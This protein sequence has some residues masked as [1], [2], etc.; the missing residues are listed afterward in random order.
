M[1]PQPWSDRRVEIVI[2]T[3]LRVGVTIAA[4]VVAAGG[5]VYLAHHGGA[6]ADYRVFQGEPADL[7]GLAGIWR[8]A[9]A[10]SGRGII[11][12]GLVLLIATPVARVVFSIF[13]FAEE[14]DWLYVGITVIVLSILLY[15]MLGTA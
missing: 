1:T 12:L 13:G 9:R 4:V 8:Q 14:R 15:S 10:L 5:A 7:D 3:L 6:T 11:Q 2:G